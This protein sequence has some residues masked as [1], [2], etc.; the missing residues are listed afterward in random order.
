[1]NKNSLFFLRIFGL[2]IFLLIIGYFFRKY[3]NHFT[4]IFG[5]KK[6]RVFIF[7]YGSFTNSYIQKFILKNMD[8][9]VHKASLSKNYGFVRKWTEDENG[10][11]NLGIFPYN[12]NTNTNISELKDINGVLFEV[13]AK[14][15]PKIDEYENKSH[16]KK[17]LSWDNIVSDFKYPQNKLVIYIPKLP[18]KKVDIL[19]RIP[20]IYVQTVMDGF[21]SF[22]NDYLNKFMDSTD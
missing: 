13:D 2:L 11:V 15:F 7:G 5:S 12:K 1:M 20:D 8:A 9:K 17:E 21:S 6:D 18:Y 14:D 10:H 22:G 16:I 19:K 3:V 4:Y